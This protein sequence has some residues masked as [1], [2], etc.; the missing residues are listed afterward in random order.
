MSRSVIVKFPT[1]DD[2]RAFARDAAA[3]QLDSEDNILAGIKATG[4][5]WSTSEESYEII[6][7]VCAEG[8]FKHTA[9]RK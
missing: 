2:A 4:S 3:R 7:N 1:H 5:Y 8:G 9:V 6:E